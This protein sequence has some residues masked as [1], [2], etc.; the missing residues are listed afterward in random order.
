MSGLTEDLGSP[1]GDAAARRF[2]DPAF[3][4]FGRTIP[5]SSECKGASSGGQDQPDHTFVASGEASSIQDVGDENPESEDEY[6]VPDELGS[7]SGSNDGGDEEKMVDAINDELGGDALRTVD[8]TEEGGNGGLMSNTD[9]QTNGDESMDQVPKRPDKPI[10]CP[11]CHSLDTKFCYFNNYN[12]NQPRHFCKNCQRYWTA[13]GTLRN[14]PVGAGR[15]KNKHSSPHTRSALPD[16]VVV[17]SDPPENAQQLVSCPGST[18]VGLNRQI[19]AGVQSTPAPRHMLPLDLQS[20]ASFESPPSSA[21]LNFGQESP[22]CLSTGGATFTPCR[23]EVLQGYKPEMSQAQAKRNLAAGNIGGGVQY[24]RI[25]HEEKPGKEANAFVAYMET[26]ARLPALQAKQ[27]ASTTERPLE[28]ATPFAS[29]PEP[30]G[31]SD[32]PNYMDAA[33]AWATGGPFSFMG[34]P[35]QYGAGI[36]WGNTAPPAGLANVGQGANANMPAA[37]ANMV[38]GATSSCNMAG[39]NPQ[40]AAG[41]FGGQPPWA[42]AIG[43]WSGAIPWPLMQNPLWVPPGWGGPWTMPWASPFTAAAAAAGA[44]AAVAAAAANGTTTLGKHPREAG[45]PEGERGGP[46]LVPKTLRIDDPGE[47]ARSSIW[48]TLG[49]DLRPDVSTSGGMFRDLQSKV[50]MESKDPHAR[51]RSSNPAAM[52]RSLSFQEKSLTSPTADAKDK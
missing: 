8:L 49:I 40:P 45:E 26:D 46:L 39:A 3:K 10:P 33:L 34:V 16:V 5:V 28:P 19:K 42:T 50:N 29:K 38:Q 43:P 7:S 44:A 6:S 22:V 51:T 20:M 1:S 18:Q 31:V 14:V 25:S 41:G 9:E 17:R 15:R 21:V 35:W 24:E 2:Y 11:R 27:S 30:T 47:A 48:S 23:S 4:L 12:V 36:G 52:S 32:I 37:V 13:G